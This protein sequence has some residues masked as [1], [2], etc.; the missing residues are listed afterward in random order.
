MAK[1]SKR[2]F[3]PS[4]EQM[5]ARCDAVLAAVREWFEVDPVRQDVRRQRP[6]VQ[7]RQCAAYLLKAEGVTYQKIASLLGYSG[8][9]SALDAVSKWHRIVSQNDVIYV[10]HRAREFTGSV[11]ALADTLRRES[12][13]PTQAAGFRHP[14]GNLVGG[15]A[16][17]VA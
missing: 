16:G 9:T 15:G 4:D 1:R 14:V 17:H 11:C 7:A 13:K 10:G 3:K 8:H 12:K 5:Q 6:N 2:S